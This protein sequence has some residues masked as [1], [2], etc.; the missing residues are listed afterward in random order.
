MTRMYTN[1][2]R[3]GTAFDRVSDYPLFERLNG[4]A[5]WEYRM[6]MMWAN[7]LRKAHI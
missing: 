4:K 7:S 5:L 1:H 3:R 2:Y 6:A